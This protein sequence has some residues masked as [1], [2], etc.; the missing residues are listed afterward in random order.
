MPNRSRSPLAFAVALLS[1]AVGCDARSTTTAAA[2]VP[3]TIGGKVY[4]LEVATDDA[5]RQRGLMERDGMPE[6]HGMIF[7]FPDEQPLNFWMKHTRFPLDIVYL[8]H[9]GR[10]VSVK[11]MK[12]VRPDRRPPVTAPAE[13]AVE[14]N[15]GRAAGVHAGDRLTLP[16]LPTTQP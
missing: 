6:D 4:R 12:P 5:A 11:T 7:V 15:A 8:D 13:Y 10:V 1:V 2:T 16:P 9:A 3:M 14:L